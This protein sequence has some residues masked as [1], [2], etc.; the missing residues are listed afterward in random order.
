[1][2]AKSLSQTLIACACCLLSTL[3]S[4]AQMVPQFSATPVAGCAPLVVNFHDETTGGATHWQ[5]DLGNST[6]SFLPNPSATY[7]NPGT[8]T[9]KLVVTNAAGTKDSV[10]KTQ[11]IT[12]YALPTVNFSATPLTGCY[13]LPVTF[14]DLSI[15]GSGTITNWLW[16][17]GDGNSSASP[18]PSHIYSA[19]GNYNV[20]LQITNSNGCTK[21]LT[22]TNYVSIS[23]GVHADFI[24]SVPAGCTPP[25]TITFTNQSTGTGTLTYEW[26]FG[27]G[28]TSTAASPSHTYTAPGSYTVQ[29]IVTNSSGCK[30]TATH[31]NSINIGTVHAAFTAPLTACAGAPVNFTNT[32][33]PAPVSAAWYFGDA[34]TSSAINP[35]KVYAAPGLYHVKLVS[36]FGGCL[37]SVIHDITILA[38]PQSAFTGSPVTSCSAPHTV[39]FNNTSSGAVSSQWDFGDGN[40]DNTTNPS[41]TYT[42]PGTYTVTLITTNAD[43]CTDTLRRTDYI[44][45]QLPEVSIND[46]PQEGC[47]PFGWAFSATVNSIDPVVSYHWDF[48][49]GSTSTATSPSHIFA[50]GTYDIQLV[51]TTASGCTDTATVIHGIIASVKPHANFDATPRDACAKQEI[52]FHD[53]ST[54][55]V[56]EWHWDF[57]DGGMSTDQNPVHTYQDTGF[58]NITLIVGNHHCFDTI[59]FNNYIHIRPPIAAFVVGM[60]CDN[61]FIR[62]FTDASIGADEW[63]W[64]FG[65]GGT[66][67]LPNPVHTYTSV[68]IYTVS[69]TVINNITGCDHT[70]TTT[71]TIADEEAAF[72]AAQTEL[73]RNTAA[74]FTATSVHTPPAIVSYD[75]DFGDGLTGTGQ[76]V[77]HTYTTAG[78]Y[79]VR[80]I[81]TDV[82]GC[83]DTLV[84][85]QYIKVNGPA[86]A[87]TSS[88][89]GSCLM[90][91]I[92]FTDGST[93]DG[94]HAINQWHWYYGD[95]TDEILTAPPF[96]HSY[97]SA[98]IYGVALVVQDTYGC[99]DSIMK[100]S[101]LVISTPVAAFASAD[102]L[103]CPGKNIVFTNASTGPGLTYH[104][105]FGDGNTSTSPAPVHVYAADGQYTVHLHITDQ[106]GCT[107]DET[108]NQYVKIAS[109]VASFAVS[110]SESTCPPLIVQ[111]TNTSSNM[112]TYSWDFGDG[113]T[114]SAL[115]PSHFYNVA[116]VYTAVLTI[117]SKG[118]CISTKTKTIRVN[119]PSGTFTYTPLTGCSP[120]SVTF[121]ATTL[122]RSSFV[123]DFNDGNTI[124]TTDSIVTHV[125]TLPGIYVPKM[126]LRDLGG[127]T[128]AIQGL[129]TIKVNGVH[130]AF[131]PDTTVR[132]NNGNVVFTNNSQ[133]ND[134]ITGYQWNFGDG[135]TS[136]DPS[137]AHYYAAVGL[138]TPV[139]IV[140][141]QLGCTDTVHATVPV[142]VVKTPEVSFTQS[143][144]G[145]APLSIH[146]DGVL[147][148]AD[149][150]AITWHWTFSDGTTQLTQHTP[151]LIFANAGVYNAELIVINS[152]GCRD[153]ASNPL[154]VYGI[155]TISA[156]SDL[157]IC[158]GTGQLLH[159][160]GGATYTWSPA[161]GLSCTDC[162][163]PLATP[164]TDGDY[165]VTGYSSHGCSNTDN[166]HVSVIHPFHM[167]HGPGDT[168]CVGS[169][170]VLTASGAASYA[171]SPSAGLN[172]TTGGTVTATPSTTTTYMAVG[173]DGHGCF[174]DTAYYV[175]KVYPIP[176][177]E[178]G[179][180]HTI[181]VGQ[182]IT[183]TPTVSPD[184]TNV[185]WSPSTG[186]VSSTTPSVTV[187]PTMDMEY[188]AT[189]TNAGGC[190][191]FDR[192]SVHV[193]CN[194][195]NVYIPNTFSP[196]ADGA[197]D[198]FYPRGTGLFTIKQARIFNRW[199]EEVYEKYGFNANDAKSG[200]DGTYKGQPALPDVYVYMFEIQCEN[201]TT[202]IYKGNVTL[203]K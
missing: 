124:A 13:P 175:V 39:N 113:N 168:L 80:L 132:C 22:K 50:A 72:T 21:T 159:A 112:D 108:K 95:G 19:A 26:A 74:S 94:T 117:T 148:N 152:S 169:S 90:T 2:S 11:Y 20:S 126:I 76:V 195:A 3:V 81:I 101:L 189:A 55:T 100:P 96:Q 181:N 88:V 141:T 46:L 158:E 137:P 127:C 23:N 147:T 103:S 155:P 105:D 44:K 83:T 98:G 86:A 144:N 183:I 82:N 109:P 157:T 47:A 5:W 106:Y 29:L 97:S 70:K 63:H 33:N 120:L 14:T 154:E 173:F 163:S 58:F 77:S 30:D 177:I 15:P 56:D 89:P 170:K 75:W 178:A 115:S 28:G 12:V 54:G 31:T 37:D 143:P 92:S 66:S 184:V 119:G 67:T 99:T 116:G 162:P 45:I 34:T 71:V 27:D 133:S 176:V 41:H 142:K 36:N 78:S 161:A 52:S 171:W 42:T 145:C 172:T 111:F 197:N 129:D 4:K 91:A 128:V 79:S 165:T 123:W 151:N 153:T 114:S 188:K 182:T 186:I 9:V 7:F 164:A 167:Q 18:N 190:T 166:V 53:L 198:I 130:A 174:T 8:Y 104:W 73:C 125:Y 118:G 179:N 160:S 107:S 40:T 150:S 32:S 57:G 93:T 135:N 203:I 59:V 48:G 68:G 122:A 185:V 69:L 202:M 35:V 200:W 43:G 131:T 17:F 38:K 60:D 16:D 149:T 25:E 64:D 192:V 110:D 10:I 51:I 187:R 199:G 191:S 85:N 196:N 140:N 156:G 49:D 138:Y 87:F 84:K 146:F 65:D 194:G 136:T 134:V 121:T 61:H 201:N 102:T 6:I 24:N 139:L 1:M 180:D 193:L 62:T